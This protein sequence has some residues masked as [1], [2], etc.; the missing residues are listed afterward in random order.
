MVHALA[1][2]LCLAAPSPKPQVC[3]IV[4]ILTTH[5]SGSRRY[6]ALPYP[7]VLRLG[8]TSIRDAQLC[9]ARCSFCLPEAWRLAGFCLLPLSLLNLF[10]GGP[11]TRGMAWTA[12]AGAGAATSAAAIAAASAGRSHVASFEGET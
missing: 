2:P 10:G 1:L 9:G 6:G 8:M 7:V 11:S 3:A 4:D 12:C 5:G